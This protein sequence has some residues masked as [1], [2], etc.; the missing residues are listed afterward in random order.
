MIDSAFVIHPGRLTTLPYDALEDF[1]PIALV[2]AA[3]LF[4]LV[5]TATPVTSLADFLSYAKARPGKVT[6][7][8]ATGSGHPSR[9]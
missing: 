2:R 1:T 8:A 6:Y 7:G 5:N 4:L 9:R 3:R